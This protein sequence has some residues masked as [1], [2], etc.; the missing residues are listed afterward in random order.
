MI[1]ACAPT[2]LYKG[3]KIISIGSLHNAQL[4]VRFEPDFRVNECLLN[5]DIE[6][7]DCSEIGFFSSTFL[8]FISQR[9]R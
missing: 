6:D 4:Y 1:G 5:N 2:E 3:I 7:I 8:T 9:R